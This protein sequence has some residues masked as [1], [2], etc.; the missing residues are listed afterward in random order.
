M[1]TEVDIAN[2]GLMAFGATPISSFVADAPN[3]AKVKT[4]YMR[5]VPGIFSEYPWSFTKLT[6]KLER[7]DEPLEE[8]GLLANGWRC[9][10]GLPIERLGNPQRFLADPRNPDRPLR[11]FAIEGGKVFA[12]YEKLWALGRFMVNPD[13]WPPYFHSAIVAAL[14]AEL[15]I[16]IS[17]NAS[18]YDRLQVSAYGTPSENRRGGMLGAAIKADSFAS[19]PIRIPMS[20][21]LVDARGQS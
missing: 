1:T 18:Q 2:E 4:V 7:L 17:G 8:D 15:I 19:G 14:S 10:F 6:K 16:P 3:V 13:E 9:A 11:H 20:N 5:V 12:D 21:P